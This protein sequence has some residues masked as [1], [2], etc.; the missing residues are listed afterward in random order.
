[1]IIQPPIKELVNKVDCRYSLVVLAS[2]RARELVNGD[3]PLIDINESKPI[4]IALNE[5]ERGNV[6]YRR[7]ADA[8]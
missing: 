7:P 3:E 1:M 8:E 6:G 5:I 4:A 2:K